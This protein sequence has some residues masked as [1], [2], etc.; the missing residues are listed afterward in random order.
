MLGYVQIVTYIFLNVYSLSRQ[1]EACTDKIY[2]G[3]TP[4]SVKK[5]IHWFCAVLACACAELTPRSF[6]QFWIFW[7]ISEIISKTQ[8]M[9]PR[10]PGDGDFRKS[11]KNLW[12]RAVLANLDFQ[13]FYFWLRAVLARAVLAG[14]ESHI[15]QLSPRKR[16]FKKNHL[17]LFIRGPDGFD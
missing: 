12:H 3:K 2:D 6:I 14:A 10:F 9:D 11:K 5:W 16:I 15:L 17:N 7:K 13:K 4:R 1:G 8:Q